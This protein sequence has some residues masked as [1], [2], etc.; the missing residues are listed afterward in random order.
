[1]ARLF[2][3]IASILGALAVMGGAFGAHALKGK[4]SES[5]LGSFETGIR[6]QMYHAIA[7][8]LVALLISQYPQVKGFGVAGW[9]FVVG[10]VLFSGSLYGLSLANI[11]ALGPVTPLGGLAFIIGWLSLA[12]ASRSVL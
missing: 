12:W 8:L 6:Y 7:L 9:G 3:A 11:K 4:L 1:M 5:A 2:L 10:V